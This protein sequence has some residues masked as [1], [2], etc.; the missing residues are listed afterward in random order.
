MSGI[1]FLTPYLARPAKLEMHILLR[2]ISSTPYSSQLFFIP[3]IILHQFKIFLSNK[4]INDGEYLKVLLDII[5]Y[6]FYHVH[7]DEKTL[8]VIDRL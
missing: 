7:F 6:V 3:C 2:V 1:Y 5:L 4:Q 8:L